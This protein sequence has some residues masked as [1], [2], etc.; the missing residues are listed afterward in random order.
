[1]IA[2]PLG[3]RITDQQITRRVA[4]GATAVVAGVILFLAVGSPQAG[5]SKPRSA[6]WWS[7]CIATAA[8]VG[9][10]FMLGRHRHGAIK[11]LIL[12]SAAGFAFALQATVTKEF[13][14]LLGN[15]I[16]TLL[17]SWTIYV[18]IASALIGFVLQQSALKTG[19][20]APAMASSNALTLF[21]S[22]ILGITVFGETLSN[23]NGRLAPALIGLGVAIMG[24]ILLAG[25]QPPERA[26]PP[27]TPPPTTGDAGGYGTR[28]GGPHDG[29]RRRRSAS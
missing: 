16:S 25:A 17:S 14:T 20:L 1:M 13:V 9:V 8:I 21:A 15:G 26:G 18:L 28:T 22:V 23:G 29:E 6:A 10:M 11:A 12:G 7:A 27:S 2:L 4:W 3:A 24:I 5:T 19:V